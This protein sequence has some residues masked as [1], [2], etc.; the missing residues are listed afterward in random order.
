MGTSEI[1]VGL[2]IGTTK[3]ATIVGQRNEHGKLDIQNQTPTSSKP[4]CKASHDWSTL[5]R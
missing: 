5:R 1:I 3:I 2:D 4:A